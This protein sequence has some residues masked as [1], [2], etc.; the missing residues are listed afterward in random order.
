MFGCFRKGD[1]NDPETYVAAITSTLARYPESVIIAVTHPGSG[2]PITR[3]FLP[4]VKEVYEACEARMGPHRQAEI[5]RKQVEKQLAE[6]A[7]WEGRNL[8]RH[9]DDGFNPSSV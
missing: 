1:A 6:R 8:P 4:S 3:D 7:E 5:W 9:I 2:L